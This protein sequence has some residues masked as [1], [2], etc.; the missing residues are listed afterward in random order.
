MMH[1]QLGAGQGGGW[2]KHKSGSDYRG[3]EMLCLRT[4]NILQKENIL[5]NYGSYCNNNTMCLKR[6]LPKKRPS[7]ETV[8][9]GEYYCNANEVSREIS[10]EG[11]SPREPRRSG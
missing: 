6:S 1:S 7:Q 11:K 2:R 5:R 9:I 10:E 4:L 8:K 3:L